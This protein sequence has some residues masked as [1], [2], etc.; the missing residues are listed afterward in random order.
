M[1]FRVQRLY[2]SVHHLGETGD[3]IDRDHRDPVAPQCLGRAARGDDLPAELD[4]LTGEIHDAA[5]V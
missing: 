5:F 2:P 3:L 4:E 1:Y